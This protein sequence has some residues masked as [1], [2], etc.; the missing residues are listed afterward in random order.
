[1][2]LE[3]RRPRV[4]RAGQAAALID[5]V[6]GDVGQIYRGAFQGRALG[7]GQGEEAVDQPLVPL[8]D[9]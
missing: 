4:R 1:M 3:P 9:R 6:L 5:H 2:E 7:V 8:V